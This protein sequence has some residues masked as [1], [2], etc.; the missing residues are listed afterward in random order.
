MYYTYLD[1]QCSYHES[2]MLASTATPQATVDG[3]LLAFHGYVAAL[4]CDRILLTN[5][6]MGYQPVCRVTLVAVT[7]LPWVWVPFHDIASCHLY[8]A[9]FARI[10]AYLVF[11]Y[12]II[13]FQH[14]MPSFTIIA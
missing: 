3:I 5:Q 10:I 11:D 1:L 4:P 14:D 9:Q 13:P 2:C 6:T 8:Y 7:V 12:V